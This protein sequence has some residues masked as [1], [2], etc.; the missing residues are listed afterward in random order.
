MPTR[1]SKLFLDVGREYPLGYTQYLPE[2][3]PIHAL[4][5]SSA[6]AVPQSFYKDFAQYFSEHG[7]AVY[8][9]DYSGFGASGN[10]INYLKNHKYGVK[11]WGAID[12]AAMVK[13]IKEIHPQLAI[14]LVCHSIGGQITGFNPLNSNFNKIVMVAC[15]SGFWK[16]Y[17]GFDRLRLW[18]FWY[19]FIPVFTPIFGY[20]PGKLLG[21]V[22]N[23]PRSTVLEWRKWGVSKNY[24][25]G[26]YNEQDY[27]FE[28][29]QA[30]TRSYSFTNDSFASK[31]G[32]DWLAGQ[33]KNTVFER[34]H[35]NENSKGKKPGHFGFFKKGFRIDFWEPTLH[36]LL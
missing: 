16:T 33:Y 34:I 15:Q 12:Q 14:N 9:F 27:H 28:T 3:K 19:F 7:F 22:D 36:W 10:T 23:L 2:K 24:F 13:Q 35:F 31:A 18:L 4:L 1:I 21:I 30:P 32:V 5:I 29:L 8:T 26:F 11:G 25:M 17:K 6:T 20:F